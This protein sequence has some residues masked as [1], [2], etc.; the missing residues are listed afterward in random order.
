MRQ[1]KI[2]MQK[3][4]V[5]SPRI[6]SDGD[7]LIEAA[8][9]VGQPALRLPTFRPSDELHGVPIAIYGESL[10][11]IILA[12]K[13]NHVVI[14]PT[15]DWLAHVAEA[16]TKRSITNMTL[17]EAR[18]FD[19]PR[20]V[21]NADGMKAFEAKIYPSG[22]KLP[23]AELYPDN[24]EVIVSEPV[25]WEVEYRCFI[26]ERALATLSV[27]LRDGE[28][29]RTSDGQWLA[30]ADE[31]YQAWEFCQALL[32]DHNLTI[33]PACVI[34]IGRIAGRGWAIVEANPAYGSGIYG[35][36]PKQVLHVVNRATLHADDITEAD[37]PWVTKYE[38]EG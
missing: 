21:K 37:A 19:S 24:Y 35:C 12:T 18:T 36:D 9:S 17:G 25:V 2:V 32:D 26:R 10:F 7:S 11:A 13:L 14:E 31:T 27:Y 16:F 8:K 34:D 23:T 30:D 38:V 15:S 22:A 33:P 3:T 6:T 4:L 29:A 20:F 5:T 28:L 1:V